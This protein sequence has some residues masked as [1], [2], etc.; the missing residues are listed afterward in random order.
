MDV[1]GSISE[2]KICTHISA[3]ERTEHYHF[4]NRKAS[5]LIWDGFGLAMLSQE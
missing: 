1:H 4:K 3:P 2:M 5:P